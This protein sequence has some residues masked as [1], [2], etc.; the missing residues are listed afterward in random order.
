MKESAYGPL[1]VV[2]KNIEPGV[3]KKIMTSA[4]IKKIILKD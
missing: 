1:A 2:P 3:Y 4:T